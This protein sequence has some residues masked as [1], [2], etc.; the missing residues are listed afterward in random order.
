[1]PVDGA[2][3]TPLISAQSAASA[4]LSAVV[5]QAQEGYWLATAN[6][7]VFSFGD[8]T[9]EG[10]ASGT[11]LSSPIVGMAAT[12]DGKGYWLVDKNGGVF[13]FGD[14]RVFGSLANRKL[15]GGIVGM[16]ATPDG[17]GYW[18]VD[19]HG[20]VFAFGDARVFGS[21]ANRKLQGGIIGMAATPDGKGYWS[22]K[23]PRVIKQKR[24]SRLRRPSTRWARPRRRSSTR[25]R[26]A[27]EWVHGFIRGRDVELDGYEV[28][29]GLAPD[30]YR[31]TLSG[32]GEA[33]NFGGITR[34][35]LNNWGGRINGK[36]LFRNR[37]A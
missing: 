17:K 3:T 7:G 9:K 25:P 20:R 27:T 28:E 6:G 31:I 30:S 24:A 23:C 21:L 36:Y 1:M 19:D 11:K 16:A 22:R 12:P 26:P 34:T 33:G 10:G 13:A 29:P 14:A 5:T 15:Q 8:A 35:P 32:D 18:I 2:L 37:K 4:N